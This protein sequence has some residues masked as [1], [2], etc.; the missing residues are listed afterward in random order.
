MRRFLALGFVAILALAPVPARADD[1]LEEGPGYFVITMYPNAGGAVILNVEFGT[2][3]IR[4]TIVDVLPAP[5][6]AFQIDKAGGINS[7]VDIRYESA[8]YKSKFSALYKPG[9][10]VIDYGELKKK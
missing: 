2:S 9:K 10:T 8:F 6:W 5:G 4:T 1:I 7:S 3:A